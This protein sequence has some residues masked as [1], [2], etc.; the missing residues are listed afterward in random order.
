MF[1]KIKMDV[2]YGAVIYGLA[3]GMDDQIIVSGGQFELKSIDIIH[4]DGRE[5]RLN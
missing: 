4:K 5:V 1:G 2:A 3:V